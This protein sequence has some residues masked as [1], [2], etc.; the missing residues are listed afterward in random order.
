MHRTLGNAKR[1][2]VTQSLFFRGLKSCGKRQHLFAK[3]QI[4][5]KGH[6]AECE[7][8]K[9]R[10]KNKTWFEAE[11]RKNC[12]KTGGLGWGRNEYG[13]YLGQTMMKGCFSRTV[14][15]KI[16]YRSWGEL[17]LQKALYTKL[18]NFGLVLL[19]R[20]EPYGVN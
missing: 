8:N 18:R 14:K 6:W 16:W 3:R 19:A 12:W 5:M 11:A 1:K 17:Q 10:H 20:W 7:R 13:A 9:R 15:R 2:S 4:K